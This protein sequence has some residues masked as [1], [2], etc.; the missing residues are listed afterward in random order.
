MQAAGV[1]QLGGQGY[2]LVVGALVLCAGLI[3]AGCRDARTR[4]VPNRLLIPAYLGAGLALLA[5]EHPVPLIVSAVVLGG[6][7]LLVWRLCHLPQLRTN[8]RPGLGGA[9]VKIAPA[10]GI[11][12]TLPTQLAATLPN[13]IPASPL[14]ADQWELVFGL[15]WGAV[16]G[17]VVVFGLSHAL[18]AAWLLA[19]RRKSGAHIPAML[20]AAGVW[21]VLQLVAYANAGGV[22]G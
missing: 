13:Q 5:C 11:A 7:Y 1:V 12:A 21:V 6:L 20:L 18:S 4:R 8:G 10:V 15:P 9:D 3:W 16:C 19:T 17:A 22:G 2:L 14:G